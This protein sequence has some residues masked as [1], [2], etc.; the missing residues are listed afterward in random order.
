[1]L[2]N[3][4][5]CSTF[6]ARLI[7]SHLLESASSGITVKDTVTLFALLTRTLNGTPTL[8]PMISMI[9][10]KYFIYKYGLT[11]SWLLD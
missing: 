6:Q 8:S 9:W 11:C 4:T 3:S 5:L 10:N 2:E 7:E 1:M